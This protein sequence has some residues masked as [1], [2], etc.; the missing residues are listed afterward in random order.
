[1]EYPTDTTRTIMSLVAGNTA[2]RCPDIKFIFSH[3]GGTIVSIAGRFLGAAVSA[4][5]LAKPVEANSRMHHI[6]RFYYDTAGS[7]NPVQIQSLKLLVPASQIVF[8][9]DFPF[10]N[11]AA[12]V[13]GLQTSG[14]SQEELR[15]VYRDNALK[16]LPKYA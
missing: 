3:A 16:F 2:T 6:R 9:T 12:T 10:A 7:A 5:N 11:P 13:A 14:L 8:G 15:G 4:E 1:L